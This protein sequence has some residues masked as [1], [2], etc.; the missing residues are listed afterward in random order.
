M[1][2]AVS[3]S[4]S[5]VA[6]PVDPRE[7]LSA[8]RTDS[9]IPFG[10]SN[11]RWIL[12]SPY[13]Y[14]E[15]MLDRK[16]DIDVTAKPVEQNCDAHSKL[17]ERTWKEVAEWEA[18]HKGEHRDG[19][20]S[21]R[22]FVDLPGAMSPKAQLY[23]LLGYGAPLHRQDWFIHRG[24][25]EVR[26][27]VDVY[28]DPAAAGAAQG[29]ASPLPASDPSLGLTRVTVV[30]VRPAVDDLGSALDRL[31]R[32]PDRA[33]EIFRRPWFRAEGPDAGKGSVS[34]RHSQSAADASQP[35][36]NLELTES[37]RQWAAYDRECGA[38][39][40]RYKT[41]TAPG[42]G[43][44]EA[45]LRQI[46]RDLRLCAGRHLCPDASDK[47]RAIV[48]AARVA[49]ST[50][51]PSAEETAALIT[52]DKC[53]TQQAVDREKVIAGRR[54]RADAAAAARVVAA[55]AGSG[56]AAPPAQLQ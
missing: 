45:E 24:G 39:V 13:D 25:R 44:K 35:V 38:F 32:F 56:P 41:A 4:P 30:D 50:G 5:P 22:R 23:S 28:A 42:S 2:S 12:P 9:V 15:H 40:E 3:K 16:G 10:G 46:T 33:A 11:A 27:V 14:Y 43:V 21:L 48:E 36:V 29:P 17:I 18:L 1:G 34:V 7:A 19:E 37:D 26:Y 6:P 47:F 54:S 31:R 52:L 55:P 51:G 53:I 8:E 49:G 20:P